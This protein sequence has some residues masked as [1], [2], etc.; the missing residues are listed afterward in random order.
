[1]AKSKRKTDR[2]PSQPLAMRRLALLTFS[3]L[4]CLPL[5]LRAQ[6]EDERLPNLTPSEFE[7]R[8]EL[9]IDLPQIER[10]PLFGFGPPPR[11]YV[12]PA[13]RQAVT[14]PYDP[15]PLSSL[16]L[17]AP[18]EP[19]FDLLAGQSG[20]VE[21]GFGRYVARYGRFDFAVPSAAG[22]FFLDA[23]Y[24][25]LRRDCD[26]C[27]SPDDAFD[28]LGAT[29]GFRGFGRIRPRVE[30][31]FFTDTYTLHGASS[32]SETPERRRTGFALRTRLEADAVR[33]PFAVA[34]R[35]AGTRVALT[36]DTPDA[37]AEEGRLDTEAHVV[38]PV[39][40]GLRFDGSYG[41]SGLDGALGSDVQH[42]SVGAALQFGRP[43]AIQLA[44]GARGLGYD[45]SPAG[46]GGS[47][48]T[49]A[50][51]ARLEVPF[52]TGRLYAHTEGRVVP[53]G[54][55]ELFSENPYAAHDA[56]PRP[57]L[58]LVDAEGGLDLRPGPFGIRAWGG[59]Q[60]SPVRLFFERD[61]LTNLYE[62]NY[63]DSDT[64]IL[65]GGVDLTASVP[66]LVE[67]SAGVAIRDGR[68]T[69][70]E[71][72]IPFFAPV[73]GH[74]GLQVLVAEGRGRLGLAGYFED[75]RPEDLLNTETAPGWGTLSA[76]ASWEVLR[77]LGV[78]L[79]GER[80]VG[81]AER[82]PGYPQAAGTIM[83]GA[84]LVW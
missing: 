46:G 5:T 11:T 55:A 33:V 79:R 58:H 61:P 28:R 51:V 77:G 9:Q 66:G 74:V 10:Q 80:L 42:Y 78:V 1:M 25:G 76:E 63:D 45:A 12:V 2:V 73:V 54:L 3:A 4:G 75:E 84:R 23:D 68:L 69:T 43:G 36:D 24:D 14:G 83:G 81:D 27:A 48:R 47:H 38:L 39:F 35:Y 37:L 17:P 21:G 7:I 18:P 15:P 6:P 20:R 16:V 59:F 65:Q 62:A 52:R 72:E 31:S 70:L 67:V 13:D 40:S 32:V 8:G 41:T 44:V 57:D 30:G 34:L 49:V 53:R 50:P 26:D 82:W 19:S 22:S 64:R 60:Y 71:G 29:A 56:L